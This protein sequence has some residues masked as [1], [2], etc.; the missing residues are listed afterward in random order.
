M[1]TRIR[2]SANDGMLAVRVIILTF[3]DDTHRLAGSRDARKV[4]SMSAGQSISALPKDCLLQIL[5]YDEDREAWAKRRAKKV[6][7][8]LARF[9]AEGVGTDAGLG[10]NGEVPYDRHATR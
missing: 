2:A 9:G 1:P 10:L 7:G 3:D 6:D 4:T 5:G 8:I